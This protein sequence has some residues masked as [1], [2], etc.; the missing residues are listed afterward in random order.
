M[1]ALESRMCQWLDSNRFLHGEAQLRQPMNSCSRKVFLRSSTSGRCCQRPFRLHSAKASPLRRYPRRDVGTNQD[2]KGDIGLYCG[3]IGG[4]TG[5]MEKKLETTIRILGGLGIPSLR[6]L[7]VI[8]S[9]LSQESKENI[10]FDH[11]S[12]H[13]N[14][15]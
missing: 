4:S 6:C 15:S 1:M 13:P 12:L 10:S 8:T 5:I 14:R 11:H 3:Y 9:C 7:E 2:Y